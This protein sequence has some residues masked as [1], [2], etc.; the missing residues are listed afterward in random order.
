MLIE[1][2]WTATN[3]DPAMALKYGALKK[4][5]LAQKAI[6]CIAR[7]LLN[8]VRFV[9]INQVPYQKGIEA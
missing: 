2:A 1:A 8:R 9:L 3:T 6:V 5:M 4:R 7:K